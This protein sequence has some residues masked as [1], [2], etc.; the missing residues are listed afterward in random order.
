M[1]INTDGSKK[2]VQYYNLKEKFLNKKEAKIEDAAQKTRLLLEE[3]VKLHLV[4]DA[5]LGVF[6]SGGLDSSA[7]AALTAENWKN[8]LIT[9]SVDFE[10]KEFSEAIYQRIMAE[11]IKSRHKT[12]K[13]TKHDFWENLDDAFSAMDQPTVDGV[14][15]YFI[16]KSA[17]EAG[18]KTVL[19]GLGGDELFL[20]Y[21]YF[22]KADLMWFLHKLPLPFGL[23]AG[24]AS[25]FKPNYLKLEFLKIKN[26][27]GFY[28]SLRGLFT[29]GK[30]AKILDIKKKEIYKF[31]KSLASESNLKISGMHPVDSLSYLDLTLYMKN[32]LLRDTDF[33]SM[34]H[35]VEVRVPFLDHKLVNYIAGLP[36]NIKF[37]GNFTKPLLVKAVERIIPKEVYNR[38]KM[39]FTFPFQKWFQEKNKF[40]G[41]DWSRTWAKIVLDKF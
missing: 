21:P 19:S 32:Q 18:L 14:N 8:S 11:R 4:S 17:K 1:E 34:H 16:A 10:E 31:I 5:P 39:G 13:I 23:I 7:I 41:K 28:L 30:I 6:L 3:S 9:L 24:I 36:V 37:K 40:R 35:S 29:P 26:P 15:T 12:T 38:S 27:L 25:V 20:G 2:L 33:M 22:K